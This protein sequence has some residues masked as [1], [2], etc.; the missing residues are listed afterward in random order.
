MEAAQRD[1]T[2]LCNDYKYKRLIK[3]VDEAYEG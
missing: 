2:Q 1:I 3:T